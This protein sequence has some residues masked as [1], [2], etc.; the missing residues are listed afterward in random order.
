MKLKAKQRSA[1]IP[2]DIGQ[3]VSLSWEPAPTKP[4]AF[5]VWLIS[6]GEMTARIAAEDA[7]NQSRLP[8]F[9]AIVGEEIIVSPPPATDGNL[10]LRYYGAL[11]EA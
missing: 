1:K 6:P 4:E 2:G 7:E 9:A 11:R 3:V 8:L 10:R 5:A